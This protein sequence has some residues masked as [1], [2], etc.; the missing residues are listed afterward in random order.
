M[1]DTTR[2]VIPFDATDCDPP[3]MLTVAEAAR[4]A[5]TTPQTIRQWFERGLPWQYGTRA[6]GKTGRRDPI[7]IELDN[8]RDF[9][10][11]NT[12]RQL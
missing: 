7:V 4:F 10:A 8:L 9:I 6:D 2:R 5:C 1:T 12:R 3:E 11:R